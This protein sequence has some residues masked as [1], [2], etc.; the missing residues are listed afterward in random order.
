M[1]IKQGYPT[2][3]SPDSDFRRMT[4]LGDPALKLPSDF[5]TGLRQ[6]PDQNFNQ[7]YLYQNFPNPFNPKTVIKFMLPK[8]SM[9]KL[10]VF[11]ILG[12]KEIT[13]VSDV[14]SKGNYSY[15]FN[16]SHL[17]SGQYI[18]RFETEN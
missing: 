13:L 14:L 10:E 11:N 16:A 18:Y 15:E 3:F 9:V 7:F 6:E 8:T 12:E 4:L 17:P 1:Q 5:I 2:H